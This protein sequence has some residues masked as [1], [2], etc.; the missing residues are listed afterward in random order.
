[1]I[2]FQRGARQIPGGTLVEVAD[3]ELG[4]S[5]TVVVEH[6]GCPALA[7]PAW[8]GRMDPVHNLLEE[9]MARK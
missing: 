5:A 4:G 7:G 9:R 3:V 1:M 8:P 6:V 2:G